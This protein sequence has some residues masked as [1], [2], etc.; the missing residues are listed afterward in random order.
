M[1]S[2]PIKLGILSYIVLSLTT[3]AIASPQTEAVGQ[4][5]TLP[6]VE[7]SLLVCGGIFLL[8]AALTMGGAVAEIACFTCFTL[9]FAGRYLQG[10]ALWLPLGL[11]VL[12][13][14]FVLMEVF[15]VPGFGVFGI[16]GLVSLGTMSVLVMGSPP[17][18][19]AVFFMT[20]I[21]SVIA[22]FLV[23]RFLPQMV[24]VKKLLIL[25]PPSPAG[26]TDPIVGGIFTP[27][28]G[29]VGVAASALRPQGVVMFGRERVD[30]LTESEFVPRGQA[31][32]V[33]RVEGSRVVVRSNSPS[34][35]SIP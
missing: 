31:V 22:G 30:V 33:I 11:L 24:V 1:T 17:I 26:P 28:L 5:L 16:L 25:E 14:A 12:G 2:S 18:G 10:E 7:G 13:V 4:F 32:E 19:L 15:V 34:P 29:E 21:G 23:I 9:L 35:Q 6:T 8:I 20:T 3:R 27:E